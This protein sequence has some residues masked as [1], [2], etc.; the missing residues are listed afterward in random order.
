MAISKFYFLLFS[1]C[2][3]AVAVSENSG[4]CYKIEPGTVAGIICVDIVLTL[5]IVMVTYHC[6]RNQLQRSYKAEK[7][8]MN[9]PAKCKA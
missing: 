9:V 1:I 6:A 3:V 8:Y 7:V 2:N 5:L 4:S